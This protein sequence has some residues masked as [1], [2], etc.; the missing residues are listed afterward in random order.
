M[1]LYLTG[2]ASG[3]ELGARTDPVSM[4]LYL[5]GVATGSELGART[6]TVS[7]MKLLSVSLPDRSS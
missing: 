1:S 5:T 6:N 7:T 3:P 4:C 2:V